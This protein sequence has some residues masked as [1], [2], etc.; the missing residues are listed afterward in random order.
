MCNHIIDIVSL[1]LVCDLNTCYKCSL[2]TRTMYMAGEI[3]WKL[4]YI[5]FD[6]ATSCLRPI[7]VPTFAELTKFYSNPSYLGPA[8]LAE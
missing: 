4:E 7:N 3:L 8:N 5:V 2:F 6:N 1:L